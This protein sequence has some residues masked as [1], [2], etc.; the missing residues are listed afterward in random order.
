MWSIVVISLFC[1]VVSPK[2]LRGPFQNREKAFFVSSDTTFLCKFVFREKYLKKSAFIIHW[3]FAKAP[4]D[5][6][7]LPFFPFIFNY[8]AATHEK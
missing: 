6:R 3:T 4:S 1:E 5:L 7:N 8:S 2:G